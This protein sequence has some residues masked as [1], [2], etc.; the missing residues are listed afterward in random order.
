MRYTMTI[1]W[2]EAL[3][4]ASTMGQA[5]SLSTG[6]FVNYATQIRRSGTGRFPTPVAWTG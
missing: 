3:R 4:I 1:T 5:F 2:I 6:G